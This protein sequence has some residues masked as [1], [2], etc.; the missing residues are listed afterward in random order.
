L[1]SNY[2]VDAAAFNSAY[3]KLAVQRLND[4]DRYRDCVPKIGIHC[5]QIVF[6]SE[7]ANFAKPET[8]SSNGRKLVLKGKLD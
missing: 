5:W 2:D 3:K 8:V 4:P 7:I 1:T 6:V